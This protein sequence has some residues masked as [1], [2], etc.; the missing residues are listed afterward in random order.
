MNSVDPNIE[1]SKDKIS[2]F[3]SSGKE[4]SKAA[5]PVSLAFLVVEI[6][7]VVNLASSPWPFGMQTPT[8]AKVM[9]LLVLFNG[10]FTYIKPRRLFSLELLTSDC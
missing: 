7:R 10:D 9:I 4:H 3:E 1:V 5:G 8:R 6:F 2:T